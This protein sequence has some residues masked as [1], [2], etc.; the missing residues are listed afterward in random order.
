MTNLVTNLCLL[1][2]LRN[3][4]NSIRHARTRET[5]GRVHGPPRGGATCSQACNRPSSPPESGRRSSPRPRVQWLSVRGR[6]YAPA[7]PRHA[8]D[9]QL[10]A[11]GS[12]R[13]RTRQTGPFW[14]VRAL[15]PPRG[16][17][18]KC[19]SQSVRGTGYALLAARA[20]GG[21]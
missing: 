8:P 7:C 17:T 4:C 12:A 5:H 2:I 15:S 11:N 10:I 3:T 6:G 19:A 16:A 9:A 20:R 1:P 14:H 18:R 13:G 21:A